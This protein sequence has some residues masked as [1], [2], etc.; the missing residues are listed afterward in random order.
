MQMGDIQSML[1]ENIAADEPVSWFSK[2]ETIA[3]VDQ[4]GAV[5]AVSTGNTRICAV[6]PGYGV[7]Y[8]AV[9]V[10]SDRAYDTGDVNGDGD[11]T[12]ADATLTLT[13]YAE[14]AVS[15]HP[16]ASAFSAA[17]VD[18][19]RTI[20]LSDATLILTYYAELAVGNT[21][22]WNKLRA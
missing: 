6:I 7:L 10:I 1:L 22:D 5:T 17:D 15:G 14:E 4:Q 12:L 18:Q 16:Q 9:R 3:T 13:Y 21:P 19:D 8:C 11:I 2:D 20:T